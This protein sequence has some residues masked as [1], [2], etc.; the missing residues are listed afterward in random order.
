MDAD[1]ERVGHQPH[2]FH[3]ATETDNAQEIALRGRAR[4][5]GS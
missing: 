4:R 2:V 3:R 5:L 1:P